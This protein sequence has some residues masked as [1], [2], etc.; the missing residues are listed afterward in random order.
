[1]CKHTASFSRLSDECQRQIYFA[2]NGVYFCVI[3]K[4]QSKL[5]YKERVENETKVNESKVLDGGHFR[6]VAHIERGVGLGR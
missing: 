4:K 1:M 2:Y 5:P 6:V 3:C